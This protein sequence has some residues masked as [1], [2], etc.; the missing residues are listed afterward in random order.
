MTKEEQ[1]E[2]VAFWQQQMEGF[3]ASGLSVKAY[4]A[5]QGIAVANWYYWRKRLGKSAESPVRVSGAEKF[6]PI[7]LAPNRASMPAVEIQLLSGRSLKLSAPLDASWLQSLVQ[8]LEG[9]C[10]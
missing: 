7:T 8:V 10:G 2:R 9:P 4:C 5:Q 6:L 3:A 1:A